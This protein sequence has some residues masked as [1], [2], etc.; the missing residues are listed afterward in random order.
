MTSGW[1]GLSRGK[2]SEWSLLTDFDYDSAEVFEAIAMFVFLRTFSQYEKDNFTLVFSV[3]VRYRILNE[4]KFLS[5][6]RFK[7]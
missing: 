1:Q 7:S 2:V 4:N 6:L 5:I 3:C